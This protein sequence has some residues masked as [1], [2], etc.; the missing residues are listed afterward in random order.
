MKQRKPRFSIVIPALNE[1]KYIGNTLDCLR[2]QTF[3][4]YEII[5]VLDSATVDNTGTIAK[6][7][8]A[9]VVFSPEN[10]TC[11]TRDEGAK[12]AKGEILVSTD[13][14]TLL[15]VDWLE[16]IDQEFRDG[17][18]VALS[19]ATMPFDGDLIIKMEYIAWSL[20][21]Y[22]LS[23]RRNFFAP[24]CFTA[25]R[26]SIFL[27]IGGNSQRPPHPYL[28]NRQI[29][30]LDIDALQKMGKTKISPLIWAFPSMRRYRKLGFMKYNLYYSYVLD[31]ILFGKTLPRFWI[32]LQKNIGRLV[33]RPTVTKKEKL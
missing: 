5:V 25:I 11:P 28:D 9:K 19:G 33:K 27:H 22:L 14:D 6:E 16:K 3:P 1:E 24:G 31:E 10:G 26:R 17:K 21:R 32:S 20:M 15:P 23:F 2:H 12:H 13:A 30:G 4:D 7:Y 8:G 29:D 18:I